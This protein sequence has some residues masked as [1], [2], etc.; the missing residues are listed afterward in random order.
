MPTR[1]LMPI[2]FRL[3]IIALNNPHDQTVPHGN[4]VQNNFFCANFGVLSG[5]KWVPKWAQYS[6]QMQTLCYSSRGH[7]FCPNG[8]LLP[9]YWTQKC[10]TFVTPSKIQNFSFGHPIFTNRVQ[11]KCRSS[12]NQPLAKLTLT[13][14][15]DQ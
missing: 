4:G 9:Y 2:N 8:W 1:L 13:F 12:C 7:N 3:L 11:I 10:T 14:Y 15:P 6:P 5:A